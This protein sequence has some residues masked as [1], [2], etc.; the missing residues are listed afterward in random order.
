VPFY[1]KIRVGEQKTKFCAILGWFQN[2][3]VY[4]RLR[5]TDIRKLRA[6]ENRTTVCRIVE[7]STGRPVGT[8][9]HVSSFAAPGL[10]GIYFTSDGGD[11]FMHASVSD[12][13]NGIQ[14]IELTAPEANSKTIIV[15]RES[16]A[17]W[18]AASGH[19]ERRVVVRDTCIGLRELLASLQQ[20][21]TLPHMQDVGRI[22]N[23][24]QSAPDE[25]LRDVEDDLAALLT[26][27]SALDAEDGEKVISQSR[28]EKFIEAARPQRVQP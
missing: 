18:Q 22:H 9:L 24:S 11:T 10:S 6:A 2:P 15:L 12:Q 27:L 4:N 3:M 16:L 8:Q 14:T 28:Y 5:K 1:L 26:T 13:P 17:T 7:E 20:T 19:N 23:E 25:K 21:S